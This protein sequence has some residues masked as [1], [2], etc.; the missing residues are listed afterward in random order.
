MRLDHSATAS[1]SL[2][3]DLR[4]DRGMEWVPKDGWLTKIAVDANAKQLSYDLAIDATGAGVPSWVQAGFDAPSPNTIV[5]ES[6]TWTRALVA[7]IAALAVLMIV[8]A[9]GRPAKGRLT[10]LG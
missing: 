5:I 6:A 3:D 2:L 4:S 9:I 8:L 1:Q 7:A 10:P